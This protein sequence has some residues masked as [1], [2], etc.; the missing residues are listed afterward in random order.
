M[1]IRTYHKDFYYKSKAPSFANKYKTI[2]AVTNLPIDNRLNYGRKKFY[3]T[4]L[5]NAIMFTLMRWCTLLKNDSDRL[6]PPDAN[7]S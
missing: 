2:Q 4:D 5:N 1:T 7:K 3:C 6:V